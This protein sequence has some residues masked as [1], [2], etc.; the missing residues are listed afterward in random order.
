MSIAILA[1]LAAV[2]ILLLSTLGGGRRLA[3]RETIGALRPINEC[4]CAGRL[5]SAMVWV[6]VIVVL[7]VVLWA[8]GVLEFTLRPK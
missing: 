7:A 3:H 8:V 2:I 5:H 6:L 4:P 1:L